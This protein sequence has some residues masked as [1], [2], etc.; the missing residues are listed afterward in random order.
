MC[1]HSFDRIYV[2]LFSTFFLLLSSKKKFNYVPWQIQ[3]IC[4]T[5][6]VITGTKK[7]NE[8][9][10]VYIDVKECENC[11]K[12]RICT[13]CK[14][15][16]RFR[17]TWHLPRFSSLLQLSHYELPDVPPIMLS[18]YRRTHSQHCAPVLSDRHVVEINRQSSSIYLG[19]ETPGRAH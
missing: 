9:S 12:N 4:L 7:W 18:A 17:K 1:W 13:R 5:W 6:S 10:R 14:I 19:A 2:W 8:I 11:D 16:Q 15:N 3:Q